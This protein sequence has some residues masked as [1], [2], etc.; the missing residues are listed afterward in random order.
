MDLVLKEAEALLSDLEGVR[1]GR[2]ELSEETRTAFEKHASEK[3]E[4]YNKLSSRLDENV[5]LFFS[6]CQLTG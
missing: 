3:K 4:N 1:R 2:K 5:C 6:T